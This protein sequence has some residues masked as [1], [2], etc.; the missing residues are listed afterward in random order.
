MMMPSLPGPRYST[1][2]PAPVSL[3][4]QFPGATPIPCHECGSF[5]DPHTVSGV[6][7]RDSVAWAATRE[8]SS[9]ALRR[10]LLR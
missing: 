8:S 1:G 3:R 2:T 10:T 6:M 9:A 5:L 7:R 4:P